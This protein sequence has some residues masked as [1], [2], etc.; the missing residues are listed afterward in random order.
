MDEAQ[1]EEVVAKVEELV[2]EWLTA[3]ESWW[4]EGFQVGEIGIAYD[5][6]LPDDAE[7]VSLSCS[8]DRAWAKAG[9]FRAA[10]RVAEGS[11]SDS[12]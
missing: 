6:Q 4:P 2:R 1:R 11:D 9:L 12:V 5:V 3:A 10:M 8:D 7:I